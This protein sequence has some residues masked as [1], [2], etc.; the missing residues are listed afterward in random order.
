MMGRAG[1]LL[2]AVVVGVAGWWLSASLLPGSGRGVGSTY[3]YD[4]VSAPGTCSDANPAW[5]ELGVDL[6]GDGD[7]I[8]PGRVFRLSDGTLAVLVV[9]TAASADGQATAF[10]FSA[11]I[12]ISAVIVRAGEDAAYIPFD[13]PARSGTGLTAPDQR[14]IDQIAFCYR[15]QVPNPPSPG[16]T[17]APD[18]TPTAE[19]SPTETPKIPAATATATPETFEIGAVQT[20]DALATEVAVARSTAEALSTAAAQSEATRQAEATAAEATIAA[21]ATERADQAAVAAVQATAAASAVAAETAAAA[22]RLALQATASAEVAAAQATV[23]ALATVDAVRQTE[24][25]TA[26]AGQAEAAATIAALQATSAAPTPTPG[27]TLLYGVPDTEGFDAWPSLPPGW[28]VVGGQL[29]ADGS[30]FQGYVQPPRTIDR[31]N[32]AVEAEIRV[33][34]Q[35]ACA[36]N[37]GI[38]VRGSESGYYAGGVEWVCGTGSSVRLWALDR[39]LAQQERSIDQEW[40]TY[41]VEVNGDRIRISVDGEV[42]LEATDASFPSGGQIALWSNGVKLD[43][44]AFRVLGAA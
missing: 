22:E 26:Q 37:F 3:A 20:A 31:D 2:L 43:V 5:T 44:R 36:A 32:Y 25:A 10:D 19:I 16:G 40:H 28:S 27:E 34:E 15:I 35:P 14:G 30:P 6:A 11:S 33:A 4:G 23:A 1:R 13:P 18:L 21:L 38:V 7:A 24:L 41:R 9:V 12:R 42:V 8:V 29:M 17:A 39:L